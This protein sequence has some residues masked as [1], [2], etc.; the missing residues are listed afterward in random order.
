MCLVALLM[1]FQCN[2]L[3]QH[4]LHVL[5]DQEAALCGYTILNN[6]VGDLVFRASFLACHVQTEVGSAKVTQDFSG[7]TRHLCIS[8]PQTGNDYHLRLWLA[9]LETEGKGELQPLH[10]RCSVPERWSG[11]E[12]VCEEKYME[13]N[14][15]S[16]RS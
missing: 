7:T 15:S 3:D 10:L 5:S 4:G 9:G 2:L 16:F 13:V 12:I 11:R 14:Q 1:I 6:A 8:T